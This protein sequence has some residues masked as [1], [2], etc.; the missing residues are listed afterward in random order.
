MKR[1]EKY[2][3]STCRIE[4]RIIQT[5]QDAGFHLEILERSSNGPREEVQAILLTVQDQWAEHRKTCPI[6][7]KQLVC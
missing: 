1:S 2:G 5:V 3:M 7:S 4:A 6:C